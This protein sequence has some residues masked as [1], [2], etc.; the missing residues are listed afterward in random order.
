MNKWIKTKER[1]PEVGK[2]VLL[3][4]TFVSSQ[5]TASRESPNNH[6][7]IGELDY[8]KNWYLVNHHSYIADDI[9]HWMP[10][11]VPSKDEL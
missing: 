1:L 5:C 10:L 4:G 6:V 3:Y 7:R 2:K 11:S 9:T 8:T